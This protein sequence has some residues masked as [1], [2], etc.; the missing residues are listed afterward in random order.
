[1]RYAIAITTC[2]LALLGWAATHAEEPAAPAKD[3]QT[4]EAQ[5]DASAAKAP[6][7][8]E[9]TVKTESGLEITTLKEGTGASPKATDRVVVHYHGTFEDGKVFDSSVDRGKPATFPLNRV[10]RCW[11]EGL[12]LMKVGGK[13]CCARPRSPTAPAVR[14]RASRRT[15]RSSSRWSCS[16]SSSSRGGATGVAPGYRNGIPRRAV[17]RAAAFSTPLVHTSIRAFRL[18][19]ARRRTPP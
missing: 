3:V 7:K 17:P 11:T 5:A 13:A 8:A 1:M 14:R 6:A 4:Q 2:G 10:I 15:R 16:T 18:R 9:K 12:Q 19:G